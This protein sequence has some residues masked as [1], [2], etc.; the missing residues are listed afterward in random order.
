MKFISL[1]LCAICLLAA[2][3]CAAQSD[4]STQTTAQ[5]THTT[6][7]TTAF[8]PQFAYIT[9]DSMRVRGSAGLTGEVIGGIGFGEKVEILGKSGDWYQIRFGDGIG[10]VSGQYLSFTAPTATATTTAP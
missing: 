6:V 8:A 1:L 7:K 4:A 5:T 3:G 2:V 10:Y 9:A